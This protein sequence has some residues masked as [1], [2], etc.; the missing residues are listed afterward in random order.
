MSPE[1]WDVQ[2]VLSKLRG[3]LAE[4]SHIPLHI[5][6]Q[7]V[8]V[9]GD[10]AWDYLRAHMESREL[11]HPASSGWSPS[12]VP[13][14]QGDMGY[15]PPYTISD[16]YGSLEL[17]ARCGR[18]V[19]G[20]ADVHIPLTKA[21]R[22]EWKRLLAPMRKSQLYVVERGAFGDDPSGFLR[23]LEDGRDPRVVLCGGMGVA[24]VQTRKYYSHRLFLGAQ[25]ESMHPFHIKRYPLHTQ[26]H[27]LLIFAAPPRLEFA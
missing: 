2:A 24:C 8:C 23:G 5:M 12:W 9:G 13:G 14:Y 21:E 18:L 16:V 4:E 1:S 15:C 7:M 20:D 6:Q 17:A 26:P 22:T 27:E 3:L 25:S 11:I 19:R 10:L